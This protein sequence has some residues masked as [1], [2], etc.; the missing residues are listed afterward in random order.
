MIVYIYIYMYCLVVWNIFILIVIVCNSKS[1]GYD[2]NIMILLLIF[3]G[4]LKMEVPKNSWFISWKIPVTEW[5]M[6]ECPSYR[7]VS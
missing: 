5:D 6:G 7:E 4:F 2:M 1:L 3:E